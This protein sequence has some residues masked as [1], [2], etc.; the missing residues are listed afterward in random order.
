MSG[1]HDDV[2]SL[3]DNLRA[4]AT[5]FEEEF[6]EVHSRAL[7]LHK[8]FLAKFPF[9]QDLSS[10][11]NLKEIDVYNPGS[12]DYFFYWVEHKLKPLGHIAVGSSKPFKN[13]AEN[14]KAFKDLLKKVVDPKLSLSQKVDAEWEEIKGLGGDRH[15]AKKIIFLYN[16]DEVMPIFKTEDLE[17]F[18]EKFKLDREGEA[19]SIFG[20]PY[21]ELS[22]GQKFEVLNRLLSSF[23]SQIQ[24]F[25]K[26]DNFMFS[27]F[28]YKMFK[29]PSPR[30]SA[31][32]SVQGRPPQP[33][34]RAGLLYEPQ[35]ELEVI[36]LFAMYHRELGFP[37][38][39]RVGSEFPDAIVLDENGERKSIEFELFSK[40]FLQ[41][42]HPISECDY[43][44]C[45]EDNWK[46]PPEEVASKII[47][48][49]ER[50][51][52]ILG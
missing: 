36:V 1:E 40:S 29:P 51:Q 4:E 12:H 52:D 44:V 25:K 27:R 41:H 26:W 17:Y 23:K 7:R 33:L 30:L 24:E 34:G 5:G 13:A 46:D 22:V 32:Y 15:I 8:E 28:L 9:S 37:Y 48:L 49:K 42:Q 45:W 10:I 3:I 50:L 2:K 14:L 18:V 39:L 16:F 38:I 31:S 47:S 21:K 43:I 11:D 35:S 6:E 20:K 19:K